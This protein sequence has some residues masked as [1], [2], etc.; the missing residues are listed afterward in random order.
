MAFTTATI[1][2]TFQNAD[3]T[4][5]SGSVE[6][7]LTKR[8]T[9]GNITISPSSITAN[10]DASGK[11]SQVLA[12]NKDVGTLPEDAEWRM[13]WRI[14][15]AEP[16]EFFITVPTGGGTVELAS[17]LPKTPIGG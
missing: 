5:G 1:T 4:P 3:G 17:L 13:D 14:L 16:E 10:L 2:H 15:G 7:T 8:M 11:L 12:S 9:N 6:F